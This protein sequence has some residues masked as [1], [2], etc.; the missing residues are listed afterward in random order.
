MPRSLTLLTA[1][2][3]PDL[4]RTP[5]RD[6]ALC[7]GKPVSIFYSDDERDRADALAL[8]RACPV[9]DPCVEYATRHRER[10]IWGGTNERERRD[11]SR[12]AS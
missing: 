11:Q 2:D 8:C 7:R 12:V 6:R 5:W 9:V 3:L 4:D 1:E 10:G